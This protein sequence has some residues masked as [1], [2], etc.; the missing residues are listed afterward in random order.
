MGWIDRKAQGTI[1]IYRQPWQEAGHP[2]QGDITLYMP[3]YIATTRA[4]TIADTE[5]SG[6]MVQNPGDYR[7]LGDGRTLRG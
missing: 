4:I 1:E 6:G 2:G 3:A 7:L 5:S